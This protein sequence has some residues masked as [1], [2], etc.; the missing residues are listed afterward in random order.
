M[1]DDAI[2]YKSVDY[3]V[4]SSTNVL[5]TSVKNNIQCIWSG[6]TND[7]ELIDFKWEFDWSELKKQ[8]VDELTG[9]ITIES[10]DNWFTKEIDV[11]LTEANKIITKR[12]STHDFDDVVS[13]NYT[14]VPC[15][16]VESAKYRKMF[17][18]SDQ[19]DTILVVDGK[20]LHVSK[21]FLSYHSEYFRALFS[22]NFKEG[23]MD[24]IPIKE[25]SI[26]DFALLL[27]SFYPNPVFPNDETVEKLLEMGRRFLVSSAISIS[28]YHLLN[29]SKINNERIIWL[30]DE[31]V[32]PSLL[33]RCLSDLDTVEKVKKLHQSPEYEML[34]DNTKVKV[35][36]I[37]IKMI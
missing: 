28:D 14:L 24:K 12:V 18:P 17:L 26:D 25:V 10:A 4:N 29:N 37:L 22:S 3:V 2:E 15:I 23:Q 7:S 1:T 20:K 5:E 31:Y 33:E 19:N 13:F 27:S 16:P 9:H 6:T 34:S 21:A 36:D 32:L 35:L 11:I 30:A 8:G